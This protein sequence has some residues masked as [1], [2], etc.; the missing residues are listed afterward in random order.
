MNARTK[1]PDWLAAALGITAIDLASAPI[2]IVD[3]GAAG[4]PHPNLAGIAS[5]ST[6]LGFDPDLRSPQTG[7]HFGFQRH[8]MI[9]RA[10]TSRE[11]ETVIFQLT[12]F[13]ECSSVL[14]PDFD[15]TKLYSIGDFFEIVG[16]AA[17]PAIT[18]DQAIEQAGLARIDWLKL[19]TQGTDFDLLISLSSSRFDQL[20]IVE[21]EPGIA[22]FY[23]GENTVMQM[24]EHMLKNG[25]WLA[26]LSQQRFPRLSV[27]TIRSLG[28]GEA[29]IALLDSNPFA[30]ELRYCRSIE[31]LKS[32]NFTA[33]D[34]LAL[35][36]VAMANN[37]TAYAIEI[38]AATGQNGLSADACRALV[39]LTLKASR[40]NLSS[41]RRAPLGRVAEAC[42]PPI[43]LNALRHLKKNLCAPRS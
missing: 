6:Y 30:L 39:Q 35:W 14:H 37:H 4:A 26:D 1:A 5:I 12:R 34:Y 19:D 24:H 7:N 43:I 16:Q 22:P 23:H 31:F 36:F 11:Q 13:P 17:V 41:S 20:L 33:R 3:V 8:T 18:L 2:G 32:R 15:Q 28:L 38:A 10:V 21:V 40:T 9:N 27:D 29:D 42:I 25:F